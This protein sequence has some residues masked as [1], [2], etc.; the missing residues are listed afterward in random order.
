[1]S[2][3][4]KQSRKGS[5]G[6]AERHRILKRNLHHTGRDCC[7]RSRLP[8]GQSDRH[9]GKLMADTRR[10]FDFVARKRLLR[11][12]PRVKAAIRYV[13]GIGLSAILMLAAADANAEVLIHV[14]RAFQQMT[15]T[16]H[17]SPYA[18]WAVSTARRG[19]RTP[20]GNFRPKRLEPVW[21]PANTKAPP[22]RTRSFSPEDMRST[23]AMRWEAWGE[24]SRMAASG[25]RPLM[26]ASSSASSNLSGS[27][28]RASW[29][30]EG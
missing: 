13:T 1:M 30:N 22:C 25:S 2:S 3:S 17:G 16:V 7:G 4:Q 28:T 26:Q 24:P 27:S 29:F 15:V 6:L 14:Y 20:A 19:Y 10:L 18:V 9:R 5:V 23:A 21:Y 12:A 8:P 11:G